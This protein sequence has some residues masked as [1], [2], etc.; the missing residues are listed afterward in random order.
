MQPQYNDN[1]SIENSGGTLVCTPKKPRVFVSG[2]LD[3]RP[4]ARAKAQIHST[5]N[6]PSN[7]TK[8]RVDE[9]MM[10][11]VQ[12]RMRVR[13]RRLDNT[14]H[15]DDSD[16]DRAQIKGTAMFSFDSAV[17]REQRKR[18]RALEAKSVSLTPVK[19]VT[20]TGKSSAVPSTP[21]A[22]RSLSRPSLKFGANGE[23]IT[24]PTSASKK[25]VTFNHNFEPT[26]PSKLF[27]N[28]MASTPVKRSLRAL[29]VISA[30]AS[31]GERTPEGRK[32]SQNN[33]VMTPKARTPDAK[34]IARKRIEETIGVSDSETENDDE[35][36]NEDEEEENSSPS[37]NV[38]YEDLPV[39]PS[40]FS[41][42]ESDFD[43]EVKRRGQT[44]AQ[45]E[46]YF[47]ET[48][49]K[50]NLT[51]NNTLKSLPVLSRQEFLEAI[52]RMPEKH[53]FERQQIADLIPTYFHQW[54]FELSQGFNLLLYGYGSKRG[55][56]EQFKQTVFTRAPVLVINGYMP[57]V[58]VTIDI[59][60]K[61]SISI[62]KISGNSKRKPKS[63]VNSTTSTTVSLGSAQ[64]QIA[65]IA[66]YFS[67]PTRTYSH[68]Y[69]FINSI[70][71]PSMR[72][73]T[74]HLQ[75]TELI[76]QCPPSTIRLV[77]TID[78][79]NAPLLWDRAA[80]DIYRWL[81]KDVTTYDG[82]WEETGWAGMAPLVAVA[83][84]GAGRGVGGAVHVLKSLNLNARKM[85]KILA[86]VQ[87]AD[88]LNSDVGD[89]GNDGGDDGKPQR[90][91]TT[92]SQK[93]DD[94]DDHD[95]GVESSNSPRGNKT[96]SVEKSVLTGMTYNAFLS[97]CLES[98]CVNG[99]DNFK[100]QLGEF[101][102]H[103]IILSRRGP[104]GENVLYIPFDKSGLE[105]LLGQIDILMYKKKKRKIKKR[106]LNV[107]TI[108]SQA[109]LKRHWAK[110]VS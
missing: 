106:H 61:I 94:S 36:D 78:H 37:K 9:Q 11:A 102:D 65:N 84:G 63:S 43:R 4:S 56:I 5:G 6:S 93:G 79:I 98:F 18:K 45:V 1:E 91:R 39:T 86:D 110:L 44:R 29:N 48:T 47:N 28:T 74:T 25:A 107:Q 2:L 38:V 60:S 32:T 24:T 100:A 69:L 88:S 64:T 42:K 101:R 87:I 68:M 89:D 51:S 49:T 52:E 77:A 105:S 95:D 80:A 76:R 31:S 53:V 85:F 58:N 73:T 71:S 81:W 21:T 34:L 70:D 3:S 41:H 66:K 22:G 57:T 82:Y 10:F 30:A 16:S 26:T 72:S 46:E 35:E 17:A 20:I 90:K 14:A 67:N 62:L 27:N 15:S 7:T 13:E 96:R 75:L 97:K 108:A 92:A 50:K 109:N 12:D 19:N 83:N 33:I 23:I 103:K 40:K 55:V 99:A 8:I 104:L 59:L 54:K